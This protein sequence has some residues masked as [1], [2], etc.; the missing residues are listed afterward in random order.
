MKYNDWSL[1]KK[2][3]DY[4]VNINGESYRME[5]K[6]AGIAHALLLL[7][8]SVKELSSEVEDLTRYL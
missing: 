2:C 6:D 3:H 4:S 8:D 7:V 1:E 5:E